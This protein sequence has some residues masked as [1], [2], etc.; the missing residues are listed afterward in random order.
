[1]CLVH[2]LLCWFHLKE[3]VIWVYIYWVYWRNRRGHLRILRE[4]VIWCEGYVIGGVDGYSGAPATPATPAQ[5]ETDSKPQAHS[6][7][8]EQY[9]YVSISTF[10]NQYL[11]LVWLAKIWT[12]I[13][14]A[15]RTSANVSSGLEIH[16]SQWNSGRFS[17][18]QWIS[19]TDVPTVF[20]I[21][22]F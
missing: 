20:L 12:F 16:N 14:T 8:P 11:F 18:K 10:L 2:L 5:M 21:C 4:Q 6:G 15:C 17:C 9:R 1:M 22:W 19:T 7:I 13:S 3:V